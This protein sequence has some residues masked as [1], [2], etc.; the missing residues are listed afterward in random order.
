MHLIKRHLKNYFQNYNDLIYLI[1]Q[2][3]KGSYTFQEEQSFYLFLL[4]RKWDFIG[5]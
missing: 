2:G 4:F 3:I 5:S 1:R